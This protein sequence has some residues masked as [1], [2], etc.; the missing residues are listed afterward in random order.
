M[1]LLRLLICLLGA[2]GPLVKLSG[3]TPPK[4]GAGGDRSISRWEVPTGRLLIRP[5]S[6]AGFEGPENLEQ[7]GLYAVFSYQGRP[8]VVSELIGQKERWEGMLS[9]EEIKWLPKWEHYRWLRTNRLL[10]VA[11]ADDVLYLARS[12]DGFEAVGYIK[13]KGII[14]RLGGLLK[15]ELLHGLEDGPIHI[16]LSIFGL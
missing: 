3:Q 7:N 15:K 8:H 10:L 13:K 6:G 5:P 9:S 4:P 2:A 1:T 16:L 11:D 12:M 14:K